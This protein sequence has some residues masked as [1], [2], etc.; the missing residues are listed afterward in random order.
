MLIR[1]MLLTTFFITIVAEFVD[2][3]KKWIV[4]WKKPSQ[5]HLT[6][7][8]FAQLCQNSQFVAE[9]NTIYDLS[10]ESGHIW[11]DG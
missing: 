9:L 3:I 4:S 7:L 8:N 1:G 5:E 2:S 10:I 11:L 6:D